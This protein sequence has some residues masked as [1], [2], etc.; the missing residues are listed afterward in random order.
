MNTLIKNWITTLA[1]VITLAFA[2][3]QVYKNPALLTDPAT[4]TKIASGVG[5]LAAAGAKNKPTDP[6]APAVKTTA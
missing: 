6:T 2:G 3:L 5:L 1:G 4:D